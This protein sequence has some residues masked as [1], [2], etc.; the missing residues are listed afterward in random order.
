MPIKEW[1]DSDKP[2]EKMIAQGRNSLSNAE[3]LAILIGSG[4]KNESAVSLSRR[5]LASVNNNL[6]NLGKLSLQQLQQFKGV[7]EAKAVTILA[8]TELGKRR[9]NEQPTELI[10]IASASSVFKL[11]QP[12]IGELPHEEFWVLFLN[13]THRVLHKTMLSKGGITST[14]VDV[15][16]LFK[17]ALECSAVA[18][19]LVH[20]HP[21]GNL[22]ASEEDI[23]LTKKVKAAGDNLDIKLLDHVI[24]TNEGFIS[25]ADEIKF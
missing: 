15:R 4:S 18:I 3:L 23:S 5:I 16:L 24:I 22:K 17:T 10:R 21:A 14:T 1:S 25:L 2:R 9:S 13:N 7:G 8:A 20:N 6:T 12:I 19:V 11:M